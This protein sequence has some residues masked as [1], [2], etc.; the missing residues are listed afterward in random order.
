MK[1]AILITLVIL[2]VSSLALNGCNKAKV[3][4]PGAT[5]KTQGTD[6][7][8]PAEDTGEENAAPAEAPAVKDEKPAAKTA[9]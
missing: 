6:L 9:K 4:K 5:D 1:K 2:L 7:Q 3:E 8:K